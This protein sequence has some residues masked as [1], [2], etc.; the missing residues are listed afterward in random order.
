MSLTQIADRET[1]ERIADLEEKL[2]HAWQPG[3]I[4]E[5]TAALYQ[6][7]GLAYARC[8]RC[9]CITTLGHQPP[10]TFLR[11]SLSAEWFYAVKAKAHTAAV[12][13]AQKGLDSF[14]GDPQFLN[15]LG[16]A[17]PP[18]RRNGRLTG[19]RGARTGCCHG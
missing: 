8:M 16:T 9:G 19:M 4:I 15:M 2:E 12:K 10:T 14:P 5:L 6:A 17:Q 13:I 3:E 18:Q 7:T 1:Q 11:I